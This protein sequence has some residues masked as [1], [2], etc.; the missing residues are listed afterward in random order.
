MTNVQS[1]L[2]WIRRELRLDLG[3]NLEDNAYPWAI[4]EGLL[5]TLSKH[6]FGTGGNPH[7]AIRMTRGNAIIA[8]TTWFQTWLLITTRW[9]VYHIT[10][11]AV[12]KFN[13]SKEGLLLSCTPLP[14]VPTQIRT[15]QLSLLP[16]LEAHVTFQNWG[17]IWNIFTM[18]KFSSAFQQAP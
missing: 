9:Q 2:R 18:S 3:G 16:Y 4:N 1:A 5:R 8:S 12:G 17:A 6:D 13:F 11:L 10:K 15:L 7:I 14:K